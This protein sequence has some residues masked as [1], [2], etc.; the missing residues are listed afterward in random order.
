MMS[1][2]CGFLV[3]ISNGCIPYVMITS[4]AVKIGAK[5]V[6]VIELRQIKNKSKKHSSFI[7]FFMILL[8]P[9]L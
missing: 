2:N 1:H 8:P 7:Y 6:Y 5:N 4:F 9:F 3:Q